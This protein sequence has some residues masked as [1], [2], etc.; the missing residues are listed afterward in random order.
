MPSVDLTRRTVRPP[1]LVTGVPRSGTTWLARLLSMARG[2]ALTGREPMNPRGRQYALGGT[3]EGWTNLRHVTD[4]QRRLLRRAYRGLSPWVYSRYGHRQWAAPLPWTRLVVKDPFALLSLPTIR[5]V[6]GAQPVVVYRHPGAVLVSYR[7]MGWKPDLGE[8][9]P[10]VRSYLSAVGGS[11]YVAELPAP[12]EVDEAEA[13]GRCWSALY[14]IACDSL[15]EVPETIVVAH[16]ELAHGGQVAV[17]RLFESSNLS[18]S[19]SATSELAHEESAGEQT[20]GSSLH[21]FNRS[22]AAAAS[23]WRS[24]LTA[25][26]TRAVEAASQRVRE[27]LDAVR[28]VVADAGRV[29]G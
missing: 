18:W 16:E 24:R 15:A 29:D 3:L 23:S 25:E 14:G 7:R 26:E 4:R 1:V 20:A 27:R 11:E 17:Q 2:A 22:P 19:S 28:L 21:E 5:E 12:G 9:R 10:L 8:L 13:F 6:T